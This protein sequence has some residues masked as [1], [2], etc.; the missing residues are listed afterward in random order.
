[1]YFKKGDTVQ[2]TSGAEK[3]KRGEVMEVDPDKNRVRIKGVRMIKRHLK[4]NA[5]RTQGTILEKEGY[6]DASNVMMI[7]P[8]TDKPSRVGV[9]MED[10][11]KVRF[12]KKSGA[13]IPEPARA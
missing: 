1:M 10:G 8:S 9:R 7:D 4:P 3:G 12:A 6:L 11:K 13:V 5:Q 2:V